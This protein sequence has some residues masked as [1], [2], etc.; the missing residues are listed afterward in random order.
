MLLIDI[1]LMQ[2]SQYNKFHYNLP[3]V[4]LFNANAMELKLKCL[5]ATKTLI[6]LIIISCIGGNRHSD[7][8]K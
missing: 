2:F 5:H 7:I 8:V 3:H 1:L 4:V 6:V